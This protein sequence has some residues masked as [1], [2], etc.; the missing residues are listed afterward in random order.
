MN[1]LIWRYEPFAVIDI[2]VQNSFSKIYLI[3]AMLYY[4]G[5]FLPIFDQLLKYPYVPTKVTAVLQ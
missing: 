4:V 1:F 3:G 5:M 2:F